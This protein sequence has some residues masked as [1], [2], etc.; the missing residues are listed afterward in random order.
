MTTTTKS[1]P[2]SLLP[3]VPLPLLPLPLLPPLPLLL[4]PPSQ[5]NSFCGTELYMAPEMLLQKGHGATVDW[6][7]LGLLLCEMLCGR[8]PFRS[9]THIQTLRNIVSPMFR[10]RLSPQISDAGRSLVL[11]LL[12]RD[13][14]R[15]LGAGES[16]AAA[17][18][19][20]A[21]FAGAVT[22]STN[23]GAR[24]SGAFNSSSG[25][26]N[27]KAEGVAQVNAS[28]APPVGVEWD[29][30]LRR[31][32]DPEF[33]PELLGTGMSSTA[34]FD[35]MFTREAPVDS[36]A[37]EKPPSLEPKA[38]LDRALENFV[39]IFT[40]GLLQ[41]NDG[42]SKRAAKGKKPVTAPGKKGRR[43]PHA[44]KKDEPPPEFKDSDKG[45]PFKGFSY[46]K[47]SGIKF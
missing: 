2:G 21:F 9:K 5:S 47:P 25:A 38:G 3:P 1:D 31:E 28:S 18:K 32:I 36:V 4:P 20:H 41:P 44:A 42:K 19:A 11:Q 29:R 39:A 15:R 7:C 17:I 22:R 40:F 16:G 35:H 10:P 27:S 45:D 6:W 46:Y 26:V 8:H 24:S 14:K 30:V 12:C 34:N 33:I 23:N 37:K 13:P 43:S